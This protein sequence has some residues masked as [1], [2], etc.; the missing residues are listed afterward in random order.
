MSLSNEIRQAAR[1][2]LP[3]VNPNWRR[4]RGHDL[5]ATN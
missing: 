4:R 1:E 5:G 2:L 3:V